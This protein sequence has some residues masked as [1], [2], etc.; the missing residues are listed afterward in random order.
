MTSRSSKKVDRSLRRISDEEGHRFLRALCCDLDKAARMLADKP[1]LLN[2]KVWGNETAL[3]Y[4]VVENQIEAVRFLLEASADPTIPD[5]SGGSAI[6]E[7]VLLGNREMVALLLD[8]GVSVESVNA[9]GETLMFIAAEKGDSEMVK[10]LW[11]RGANVNVQCP[12]T[13][14]YAALYADSPDIMK[15]LLEAG[16][17]PRVPDLDGHTLL[18]LAREEGKQQCAAI[19]QH[20]L[21]SAG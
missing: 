2:R 16:A 7:A 19:L 5:E 6:T 18:D 11:V 8:H 14:L 10:L 15:L 9:T 3:H 13:P 21:N 20:A 12:Y 17:D 4:C 1:A